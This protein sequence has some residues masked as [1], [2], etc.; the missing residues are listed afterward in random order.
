MKILLQLLCATAG[1]SVGVIL[2]LVGAPWWSMPSGV[3]TGLA[4]GWLFPAGL[5][6][7][8]PWLA[9]ALRG[10]RALPRWDRMA[11]STVLVIATTAIYIGLKTLP[12]GEAFGLFLLPIVFAQVLFGTKC[13]FTA[14]LA[15]QIAIHFFVIPPR[16]SFAV[17]SPRELGL[18]CAFAV[19]AIITSV[20][21]KL[22]SDVVAG[23][24]ARSRQPQR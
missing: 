12:I 8:L 7:D 19:L 9:V 3:A 6:G 1:L 23:G 2:F 10:L 18:I 16:N 14:A 11:M 15:S 5:S 13:G 20:T 21:L 24:K 4:I 17:Q 22:V